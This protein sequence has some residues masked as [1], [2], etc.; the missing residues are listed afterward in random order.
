M[1]HQGIGLNALS[2]W[3]LSRSFFVGCMVVTKAASPGGH[4]SR[5]TPSPPTSLVKRAARETPSRNSEQLGWQDGL[6][7]IAQAPGP[8]PTPGKA[9]EHAR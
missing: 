7:V 5:W 4:G 6:A 1:A 8:T 2:A 9:S 3:R